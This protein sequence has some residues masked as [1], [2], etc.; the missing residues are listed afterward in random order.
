MQISSRAGRWAAG[1]TS[2]AAAPLLLP[3]SYPSARLAFRPVLMSQLHP[4]FITPPPFS[5]PSLRPFSPNTHRRTHAARSRLVLQARLR[6]QDPRKPRKPRTCCPDSS[7][8]GPQRHHRRSHRC[9]AACSRLDI[10]AN[11]PSAA[12]PAERQEVYVSG[13]V[14]GEQLK[15]L[16]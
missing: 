7:P 14:G 5:N 12:A 9:C 13:R 8:R 4:Y 6:E 2:A 16:L 10:A 11:S 1:S 3:S 15:D